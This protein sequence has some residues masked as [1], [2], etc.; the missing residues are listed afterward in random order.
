MIET[1]KDWHK[2]L[3]FAIHAYRTTIQT[4]TR[5]TSFSLVYGMK[6]VL[7]G[8]HNKKAFSKALMLIEMDGRD[9]S[10]PTNA[11]V[12]KKYYA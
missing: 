1:Y 3:S 7:H 2:K 9:L 5:A 12:M 10:N 11:Y 6:T 4:S 8:N